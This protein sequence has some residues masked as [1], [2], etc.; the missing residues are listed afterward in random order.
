MKEDQISILI[1]DDVPDNI[2]ILRNLLGNEY[3]LKAAVSGKKA[4]E[5]AR[6]KPQPDLILLDVMM[7]E[8][9]GYE[10]CE[11]LKSSKETKDISIIFQTS[12]NTALDE[13][14]AFELGASD[15]ITK[16]FEP[17]VVKSRIKTRVRLL[18]E[19]KKLERQIKNLNESK[20]LPKSEIEIEQLIALGETNEIEFK[21]TLRKNLYTNKNE[22][23]IENQCLKTV[24]GFINSRGGNLL[25]GIDDDGKPLGMTADGFKNNDKLLLHWFNLLKET[26]GADL[27]EFIDSEILP[28]KNEQILFVRCEPSP[29]PVFFSREDE[30]FFYVRVGNSTQSLK[31]SEMLAYVDNHYGSVN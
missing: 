29:K 7:P 16:P 6:Q 25:V 21:S 9:D 3:K 23:R 27:I 18:E 22:A 2:A 10:V 31:P 13:Q 17:D 26:F 15:F 1:V 19:R 14:K 4:L 8:M 11:I 12:K 28:Y 30:E 20:A 24:V 5:I